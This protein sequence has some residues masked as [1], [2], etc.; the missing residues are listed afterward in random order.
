MLAAAP[1]RPMRGFA[2][3]PVDRAFSVAG[4]GTVVTGTL[5]RGRL[6][7]GDEIEAG[8]GRRARAGARP[9]GAWRRGWPR[10]AR[11]ARGGQPA[12]RRAGA[13]AA[14][15]GARARPA[16]CRR[17]AWLIVQLRAVDGAPALRTRRALQLLFGTEEVEARLRLLDRDVLEPGETAL[18]QLQCAEPVAVPAREHFILRLAS[19]PLTVA[20]GRV[21][22]P[23]ATRQRRHAAAML[24][25]CATWRAAP[26]SRLRRWS[27]RGQAGRASPCPSWRGWPG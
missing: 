18:A 15:H 27:L 14:R 20:G 11:P 8:A 19:P 3:L 26:R 6:L 24:T 17:R 7:A 25:G 13:G 5:R 4:H 22:D 9:A 21:L 12:R 2:Y 23:E 1:G 10:R 16:C